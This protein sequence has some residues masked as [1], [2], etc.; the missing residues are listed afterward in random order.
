[1]AKKRKK[2][3]KKR[4]DIP[5]IVFAPESVEQQVNPLSTMSSKVEA[6]LPAEPGW[7]AVFAACVTCN[8]PS[9]AMPVVFWAMLR[10]EN[11]LSDVCGLVH[12]L[13]GFFF[14]PQNDHTFIGYVGPGQ[15]PEELIARLFNPHE[16]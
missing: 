7:K 1:M 16:E 10:W 8:T 4:D 12:G 9:A 13:D 2:G 11:G 15:D 14:Y 5:F 6:L 3:G